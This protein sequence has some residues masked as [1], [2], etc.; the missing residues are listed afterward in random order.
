MPRPRWPGRLAGAAAQHRYR[1][2]RRR[3]GGEGGCPRPPRQPALGVLA[4]RLPLPAL[5][6]APRRS[7]GTAT[8]TSPGESLAACSPANQAVSAVW[9]SEAVRGLAG[10]AVQAPGSTAPGAPQAPRQ[11][12]GSDDGL[13]TAVEAGD[14][15]DLP[16]LLSR[17]INHEYQAVL[18]GGLTALE[19]RSRRGQGQPTQD[20]RTPNWPCPE[21]RT[22][23]VK[24]P[25]HRA[26]SVGRPRRC[27]SKTPGPLRSAKRRAGHATRRPD[28]GPWSSA[29]NPTAPHTAPRERLR[30]RAL[31]P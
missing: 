26:G 21:R 8:A 10:E 27:A 13:I 20:A 4:I 6:W 11:Q 28:P 5:P 2:R 19:L 29:G 18:N 30:A 15:N 17:G 24:S 16:S 23:Q 7:N 14:Q 25:A 1:H 31:M 9:L 3:D 12:S 22:P